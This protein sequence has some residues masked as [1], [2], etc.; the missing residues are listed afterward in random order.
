MILNLLKHYI[1]TLV[2]YVLTL[3]LLNSIDYDSLL[4]GFMD[5]ISRSSG[6]DFFINRY[7]VYWTNFSYLY[8]LVLY[9]ILLYITV[10]YKSS[11]N[12]ITFLL[13]MT[14]N[15]TLFLSLY[16]YW[17]ANSYFSIFDINT[18]NFNKLLQNSI[19]K[20]HPFL[21]YASSLPV[22]Y[23]FLQN[24]VSQHVKVRLFIPPYWL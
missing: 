13:A 10:I 8:P 11:Y 7:Y 1:N 3:Y 23:F 24:F 17:S 18:L 19:N 22:F 9:L 15:V 4:S 14:L 16:L 21:F 2:F 20:Y 6:N 5:F 12:T